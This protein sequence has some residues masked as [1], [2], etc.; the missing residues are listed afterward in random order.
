MHIDV[1]TIIQS[2]ISFLVAYLVFRENQKKSDNQ[3][4]T[5]TRDYIK[6]Q[7]KRL[8]DE[9]LKLSETNEKLT[10]ENLKLQ[11]KVDEQQLLIK[12]LKRLHTDE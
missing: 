5:D 10:E 9:N 11:R 3:E 6:D 1:S 8:N 12:S 4:A 2:V 7:N